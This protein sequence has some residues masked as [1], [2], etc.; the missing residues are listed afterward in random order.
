LSLAPAESIEVRSEISELERLFAFIDQF[1]TRTGTPDSLKYKMFL[2]AEELA[3]NSISHGYAGR[4]DG[5]IAL[6][7]IRRD[8]EVELRFEDEAPPFDSLRDA[9]EPDLEASV[10]DRRI[11]GLGIHLLKVLSR[12]A[13]YVYE[14]GRNVVR[15]WLEAEAK[16]E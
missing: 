8:P 9:R 7:L 13:S 15:V 11:G 4:R 10:S 5:P 16:S 3:M 6:T 1:C 2:V 12:D 14:R